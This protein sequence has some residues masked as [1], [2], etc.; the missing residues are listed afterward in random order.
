MGGF[1]HD[2]KYTKE[3][4][5]R[6]NQTDLEE[7]LRMRG[8]K[9]IRSGREK[10]LESDHSI[11]VHGNQWYDHAAETGG[12]P[13]RF[14]Q[15]YYN[16]SKDDAI[17]SL[18]GE[19]GVVLFPQTK[20]KPQEEKQPFSLPP[21]NQNMRSLFGYLCGE[22]KINQEVLTEFVHAGLI[23]ESA[24]YHEA[25]FVGLDENSTPKHASKRS[26]FG[27]TFKG[28]A[29]GSDPAYSFHWN[30]SD[31]RLFV[32]EAP[33][34]LLSYITLHPENWQKQGYV[35]LCGISEKA[36]LKQLDLQ[37]MID[38]VSL[39]LDHDQAGI[40]ATGR[41]AER[42]KLRG[43]RFEVEQPEQ[44][45][46]NEDLKASYGLPAVPAEEHPEA[47][48]CKRIC[49]QLVPSSLPGMQLRQNLPAL[50]EQ[51]DTSLKQGRMEQAREAI[52][53]MAAL[54]FSAS[55][56]EHRN[57]GRPVSKQE[58]ADAI[59]DR[60][61]SHNNRVSLES[62]SKELR[63]AVYS[64]CWAE[65]SPD[66]HTPDQVKARAKQYGKLAF[67]C[68]RAY[69]KFQDVQQAVDEESKAEQDNGISMEVF[70]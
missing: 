16:L 45:D 67:E 55:I 44:K 40:E 34:D 22:R 32:F 33:V 20:I 62:R 8:E 24:D 21:A 53:S 23:Y 11:T 56:R 61:V 52:S 43:I 46:W 1:F 6:A 2:M 38:T 10:R 66:C 58:L 25:V 14:M 49:E 35:A 12:Y 39:C 36:L 4:I 70:Y 29:R 51:Y 48:Q 68:V 50:L 37:P 41:L 63:A 19:D 65:S 15:L 69:V 47:M 7:L 59:Q 57:S 13:V 17:R 30:G 31:T 64:V 60:F 42:L 28:N 5:A 54:S 26:C 18:I 9:L 3:Q 27:K